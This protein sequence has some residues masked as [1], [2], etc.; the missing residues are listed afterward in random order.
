MEAVDS[1]ASVKLVCDIHRRAKDSILLTKRNGMCPPV[2]KN[3]IPGFTRS[4]E[5]VDITSSAS[6]R[7]CDS[8][9]RE[10]LN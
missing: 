4:M 10:C 3:V 6:P 5:A 2:L 8:Q 1:T 7:L 9:L